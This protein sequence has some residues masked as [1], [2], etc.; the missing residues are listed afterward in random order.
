MGA[1]E[2]IMLAE[3]KVAGLQSQLSTVESILDKAEQVAVTGEKAG[4]GLRRF[5]QILLLLS[6]VAAVVLVVKKLM[7]DGCPMGKKAT[8]DTEPTPDSTV[9]EV[10]DET[11]TRNE[12]S[13]GGDADAS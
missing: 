3:E 6:I 1:V 7:G 9:S 12:A 13:P 8:G 4:R 5:V 2:K 11:P 10:G